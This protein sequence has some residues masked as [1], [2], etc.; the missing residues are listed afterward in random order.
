MI[1][2]PAVTHQPAPGFIK[3]SDQLKWRV[4]FKMIFWFP[5][6]VSD[7][8]DLCHGAIRNSFASEF[9]W[10]DGLPHRMVATSRQRV[11]FLHKAIRLLKAFFW[12][13]AV[14]SE[15]VLWKVVLLVVFF[16][17]AAA[18]IM[19]PPKSWVEQQPLEAWQEHVES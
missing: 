8:V 4:D 7:H 9:A 17:L 10:I 3:E 5:K 12:Q 14:A 13:T 1:H 6:L 15:K 19:W 16:G 18:A 2:V 11:S